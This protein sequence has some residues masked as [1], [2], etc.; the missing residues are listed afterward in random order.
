MTVADWIVVVVGDECVACNCRGITL[1]GLH[2]GPNLGS[3]TDGTIRRARKIK[4]RLGGD[5]ALL[6]KPPDARQH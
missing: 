2:I 1:C 4:V 3:V 5:Q 6:G